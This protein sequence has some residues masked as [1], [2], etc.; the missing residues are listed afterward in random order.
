[1]QVSAERLLRK[2]FGYE[3]HAGL[4][5]RAAILAQGPLNPKAV[6]QWLKRMQ[7]LKAAF[8]SLLANI[9]G[10]TLAGA[11]AGGAHAAM[12]PAL[13]FPLPSL[14]YGDVP[15]KDCL[16]SGTWAWL[17]SQCERAPAL[18]ATLAQCVAGCMALH[19][20]AYCHAPGSTCFSR[21]GAH[22]VMPH[23]PRSHG[24]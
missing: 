9:G 18:C 16:L 19:S 3:P 23:L 7:A 1:M 6:A 24:A 8:T 14:L 22:L 20:R 17:L 2:A 4:H 10:S 12:A 11:A 15:L 21:P 13:H 5:C